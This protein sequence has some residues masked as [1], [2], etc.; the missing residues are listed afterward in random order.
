MAPPRAFLTARWRY[1]AMLNY[2]V[3]PSLL[4]PLVP[5]GTEIDDR[6]G[7][8][9]IS[10]VGFLFEEMRV[11][12]IP[13]FFHRNFEEVNLRFYVRRRAADGWRRGVVFVRE[14]VPR[15]VVAAAARRLYNEKYTA[16][17]MGHRIEGFE[18]HR[19]GPWNVE[20]SWTYH[21]SKGAMRIAGDAAPHALD[22]GS[23]EEFITE[24]YW[25]YT[26]QRDGSTLE[27]RVDHPRWRVWDG[28]ESSLVCDAESL[29]GRGIAGGLRGSPSSAFI[30]EGSDVQVFPGERL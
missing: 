20:Y 6:D 10:V 17:S 27:Y 9:F 3:E 7:A 30:A 12:G 15:A 5:Q 26:R 23:V 8:S 21:G 11:M 28:A 14:L 19:P 25:G 1:I 16:V 13:A 18:G 29:Y 24:H 2:S 4:T 22:E